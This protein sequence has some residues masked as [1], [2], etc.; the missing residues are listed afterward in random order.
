MTPR[1]KIPL[2]RAKCIVKAVTASHSLD[3]NVVINEV[4]SVIHRTL[5]LNLIFSTE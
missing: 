3:K 1:S 2:C 4:N 5:R